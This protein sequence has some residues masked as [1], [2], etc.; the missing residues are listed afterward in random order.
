MSRIAIPIFMMRVSPVFDSCTRLLLVD[1]KNDREVERREIYLDALSL[2][3]RIT[4]LRKTG[5]T[6]VI[7]GGISDVMESM[8]LNAEIE[9][10]GNISGKITQVLEAY[11]E[12]RLDDSRF[13][14][15]GVPTDS[16]ING[17]PK[18]EEDDEKR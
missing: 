8:L 15:P 1:F 11:K 16:G 5:V 12:K 2:T 14:M 10:I 4:I 6:A 7:C 18:K 17:A 3:E 9:L 13:L